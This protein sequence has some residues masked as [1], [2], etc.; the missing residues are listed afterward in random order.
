M[1]VADIKARLVRIEETAGGA[2]KGYAEVP[3]SLPAAM[4]PAVLNIPGEAT[5]QLIP[6]SDGDSRMYSVSRNF[7]LRYCVTPV[8]SGLVK[9]AETLCNPFFELVPRV[10]TGRQSLENLPGIQQV[11]VVKDSGIRVIAVAG[12]EFIGIEFVLRI[13]EITSAPYV[14]YYQE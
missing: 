7:H 11:E 13:T 3:S 2:K 14:D 4:C 12:D 10:F 1:S 5:Y 9:E 8:Q 6:G